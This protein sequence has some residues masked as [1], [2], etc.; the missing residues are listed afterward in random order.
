MSKLIV[1]IA[2]QGA[3]FPQICV[4]F[5]NRALLLARAKRGFTAGGFLQKYSLHL[6]CLSPLQPPDHL[7]LIFFFF[8]RAVFKLSCLQIHESL[9]GL[10]AKVHLSHPGN[11]MSGRF[12]CDRSGLHYVDGGWLAALL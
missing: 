4:L 7:L 5:R 1:S 9:S 8:N 2:K 10:S 12:K 6:F 11:K 3:F